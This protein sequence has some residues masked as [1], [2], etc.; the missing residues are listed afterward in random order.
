MKSRL[1]K[2]VI[3][4]LVEKLCDVVDLVVEDDPDALLRSLGHLVFRHLAHLENFSHLG[5]AVIVVRVGCASRDESD[6][7]ESAL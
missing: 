6:E 2:R 5:S 7:T 3:A 1:R 4:H